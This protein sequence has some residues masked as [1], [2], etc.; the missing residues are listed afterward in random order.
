MADHPAFYDLH[1]SSDF[2]VTLNGRLAS[3]GMCA[4]DSPA[5]VSKRFT[6]GGYS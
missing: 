5:R 2:V 3:L 6:I 1:A 4:I